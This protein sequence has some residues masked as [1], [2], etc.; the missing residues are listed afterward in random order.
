MS[1]ASL[2]TSV[3]VRPMATPMSAFLS[4][5]ASLTPSPVTATTCPSSLSAVTTR[6]LCSGA[7]RAKIDLVLRA[8]RSSVVVG[9]RRRVG[10]GDDARAGR[11]A[12]MPMR[13]AIALGGEA[14]VAGDHDDADA[15]PVAASARPPRRPRAAA[16]PSS[17][18][19]R[20]RSG[21]ARRVR[22]CGRA[23]GRASSRRATASTRSPRRRMSSLAVDDRGAQLV[24]RA[25]R[26]CRRGGRACRGR[27][28]LAGAP[29]T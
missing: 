5:G 16:G 24:G 17:P 8:P 11:R 12:T 18:P 1:A 13:R 25:A 23:T 22:A 21:R 27:A 29:L 3:P 10:A 4:A 9:H 7:T 2:A 26:R 19:G 14:V 15:G 20:G 6:S 28:R